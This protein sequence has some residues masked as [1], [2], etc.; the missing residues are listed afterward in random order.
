MGFGFA[1]LKRRRVIDV[2]FREKTEKFIPSEVMVAPSGSGLPG[3]DFNVSNLLQ[4]FDNIAISLLS[5]YLG[6][7]HW[8][9]VIGY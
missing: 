7:G 2:A 5:C 6:S 3:S 4:L 9:L 1:F 8:S